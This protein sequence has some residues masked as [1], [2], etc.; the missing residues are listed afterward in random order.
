MIAGFLKAL[1]FSISYVYITLLSTLE[2]IQKQPNVTALKNEAS[3]FQQ[4]L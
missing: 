2:K 3:L 4:T 1:N